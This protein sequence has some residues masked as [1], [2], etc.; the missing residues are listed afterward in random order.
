MLKMNEGSLLL[1]PNWMFV[2]QR[3]SKYLSAE[4]Q[5]SNM[6]IWQL[7]YRDQPFKHLES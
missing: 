6:S 2:H 1:N 3:G 7:Q 4:M 5:P